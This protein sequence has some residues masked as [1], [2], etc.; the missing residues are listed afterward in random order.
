MTVISGWAAGNTSVNSSWAAGGGKG[1]HPHLCRYSKGFIYLLR[2]TS[3]EDHLNECFK[4]LPSRALHGW[5]QF[6]PIYSWLVSSRLV[7]NSTD[8]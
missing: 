8:I 6:L 7:C 1:K 2:K 4:D 5:S 3:C